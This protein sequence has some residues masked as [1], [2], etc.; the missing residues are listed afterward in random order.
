MT[1]QLT[2]TED[3]LVLLKE[4]LDS[5]EYWQ[6]SDEADR[7]SGFVYLPGEREHSG[8][9][10][11]HCGDGDCDCGCHEDTDSDVAGILAC[12]ALGER[13]EQLQREKGG[14]E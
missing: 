1:Y 2:L 6:L 9:C 5:H 11:A 10:D 7:D 4:A 14:E 12:R 8:D 3:E 13:L